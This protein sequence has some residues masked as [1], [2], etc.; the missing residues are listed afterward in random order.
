MTSPTSEK[1]RPALRFRTRLLRAVWRVAKRI[2][3]ERHRLLRPLGMAFR[4]Y[5]N[6]HESDMMRRRAWGDYES[7]KTE[8]LRTAIRPGMT[9]VDI[10]VNKGYYSLMAASLLQGRGR[11]LSFEPSPENCEWIQRSIQA[12]GFECISLFE[13]A[14]S[15]R[16]GEAE[17]NLGTT[18]GNHSIMS[19]SYLRGGDSITVQTDTLDNVLRA[20]NIEHVDVVKLDVEGAESLVLAGAA[21]TLAK[22]EDLVLV[23]D[24]HPEYGVDPLA[25]VEDLEG[26][27]F[28]IRTVTDEPLTPEA[29]GEATELLAVK[30]CARRRDACATTNR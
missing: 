14:L 23:M 16:Q 10:G 9:V 24:I 22:S 5:L 28:E 26:Y 17:L 15:D 13:M 19:T 6:L 30:P 21:D 18:S 20:E 12:N 25:I 7:E 3:P 8:L 4:L 2:V 1:R 27:G 11:V 29:R